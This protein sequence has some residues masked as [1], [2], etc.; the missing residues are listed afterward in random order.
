MEDQLVWSWTGSGIYSAKSVYSV[1]MGGGKVQWLFMMVWKSK[2]PPSVKF[3]TTMLLQDKI[4][5]QQ[6]ME[7][8]GIHCDS[9]CVI[10][11]NCPVES[12]LHLLFLCPFATRVFFSFKWIG[13]I[14]HQDLTVQA[15]WLKSAR[16]RGTR[17]EWVVQFMATLWLL[18]KHRNEVIFG[19]ARKEPKTLAERAVQ[20][21]ALWLKHGWCMCVYFSFS[22]VMLFVIR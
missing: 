4:L 12:S 21:S 3:F 7:R 6:V 5:T 11:N 22:C 20:D 15:I 13:V 17:K 1:M 9:H 18:W 14:M 16:M 2:A 10:C 19:G 8:R